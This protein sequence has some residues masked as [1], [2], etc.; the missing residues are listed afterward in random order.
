MSGFRELSTHISCFTTVSLSE[1]H[2]VFL[3]EFNMKTQVLMRTF[4][5]PHSLTS[6][7]FFNISNYYIHHWRWSII[8]SVSSSNFAYKFTLCLIKYFLLFCLS[9]TMSMPLSFSLSQYLSLC[10][11]VSLSPLAG[12]ILSRFL[13]FWLF[14]CCMANLWISG[15][16]VFLNIF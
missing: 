13:Y 15:I 7:S 5:T 9:L 8:K 14:L 1:N 16:S 10:H 6:T 11:S 12:N 3:N 2:W 4:E